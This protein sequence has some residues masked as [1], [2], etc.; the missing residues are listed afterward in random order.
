MR[1]EVNLEK[2]EKLEIISRILER[3]DNL[4]VIL[5]TN[6]PRLTL[7]MDLDSVL[8]NMQ[9][10]RLEKFDDLN[11]THDIVGIQNNIDREAKTFKDEYFQPRCW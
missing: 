6:N 9:L 1:Y 3:A 7:L 4:G 2:K 11:F 5:N 8:D 10:K